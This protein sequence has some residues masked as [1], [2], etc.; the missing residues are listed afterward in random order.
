MAG[1]HLEVA[2]FCERDGTY[3]DYY[4]RVLVRISEMWVHIFIFAQKTEDKRHFCTKIKG[5][6]SDFRKIHGCK[7]SLPQN[8]FVPTAPTLTRALL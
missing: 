4:I 8:L 1:T 2:V 6:K 5:T 7:I 3:N